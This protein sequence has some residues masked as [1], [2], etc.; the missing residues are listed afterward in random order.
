[1]QAQPAI[2]CCLRHS[3]VYFVYFVVDGLFI[4]AKGKTTVAR[5]HAHE[6]AEHAP[7]TAGL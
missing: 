1:M 4:E 7:G 2:G 3:F 6:E 5:G